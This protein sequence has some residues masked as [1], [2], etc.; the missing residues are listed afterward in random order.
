M[1]VFGDY[2]WGLCERELGT[3]WDIKQHDLVVNIL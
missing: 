1:G 3:S 2:K